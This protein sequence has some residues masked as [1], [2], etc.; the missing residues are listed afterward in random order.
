M[1]KDSRFFGVLHSLFLYQLAVSTPDDLDISRLVLS[2]LS[3][4]LCI[5][6][7]FPHLPDI[8]KLGLPS[9][10]TDSIACGFRARLVLLYLAS[11]VF[12]RLLD[13]STPG[14]LER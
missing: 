7:Y 10:F 6:R 12:L 2:T 11:L 3:Q 4:Y 8:L 14:L 1:K 9:V 5:A 13:I